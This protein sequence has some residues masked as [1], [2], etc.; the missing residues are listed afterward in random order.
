LAASSWNR[1]ASEGDFEA[2]RD[3]AKEIVKQEAGSIFTAL[4]IRIAIAIAFKLLEKWAKEQ[5]FSATPEV[6]DNE[7]E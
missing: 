4:L 1:A 5:L 7:C 2:R 6:I 3:R